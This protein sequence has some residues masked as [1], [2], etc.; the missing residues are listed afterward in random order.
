MKGYK[1]ITLTN[2]TL[3]VNGDTRTCELHYAK[4]IAF[5]SANTWTFVETV[6]EIAAYPP[7][8]NNTFVQCSNSNIIARVYASGSI[9]AQSTVV[10]GSASVGFSAM[11]HY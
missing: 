5:S 3:Y 1:A 8:D 4:S 11:W 2:G 9:Q 7:V 10:S 6:S